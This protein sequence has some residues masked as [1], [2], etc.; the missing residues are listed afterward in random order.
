ML[1]PS[2]THTTITRTHTPKLRSFSQ[3][4]NLDLTRA[5]HI[6][7]DSHSKYVTLGLSKRTIINTLFSYFQCIPYSTRRI[8]W[9]SRRVSSATPW[10][11]TGNV[12]TSMSETQFQCV[13]RVSE[14]WHRACTDRVKTQLV[15]TQLQLLEL[16]FFLF[17]NTRNVEC[18]R[19]IYDHTQ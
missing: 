17:R 3:Q 19:C 1:T 12:I 6:N 16:L 7:V 5:M 18:V 2:P 14:T 9:V 8:M 4:S 11:L 13:V 15:V 10:Y